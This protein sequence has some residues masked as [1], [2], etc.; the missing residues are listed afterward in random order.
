MTVIYKGD[1][2]QAFGK[3][4]IKIDLKGLEGKTISK[5]IFQCGTVQK[6]FNRPLFPI[7]VNFTS[8]ESS[9]LYEDAVCYFQVFDEKGRRLTSN[10]TL[11]FTTLS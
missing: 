2:T 4:F 7:Y 3:D 10:S 1:D 5:A 9:Q 11:T 6:V 8:E